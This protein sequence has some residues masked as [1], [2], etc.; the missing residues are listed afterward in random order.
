M[1]GIQ[2]RSFI[3]GDGRRTRAKTYTRPSKCW[4][5]APVYQW[6][7]PKPDVRRESRFLYLTCI[8]RLR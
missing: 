5:H 2:R 1:C 8:R 3:A 7:M 6:S 4:W